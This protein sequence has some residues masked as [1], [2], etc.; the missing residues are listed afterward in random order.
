MQ[1][2]SMTAGQC[3]DVRW[4]PRPRQKRASAFTQCSPFAL[5]S[6]LYD[7][8]TLY[9]FSRRNP[10]FSSRHVPFDSPK[11]P[12]RSK[13]PLDKFRADGNRPRIHGLEK[14]V[15][16]A[17]S[18]QLCFLPWALGTM[19]AWS[20]CV[21][22]AIAVLGFALALIPREYEEVHRDGPPGRYVPWRKLVRFPAFWIGV[23]LLAYILI[24]ALN[25][26]WT[27][28]SNEN[29]W[30]VAR[31]AHVSWLPTSVKSPFLI[32][33]AWRALMVAATVVMTVSTIWIGLSRRRS[34][35]AV[36]VVLVLNG[37]GFALMGIAQKLTQTTDMLWSMSGFPNYFFATIIYKNHAAAYLNLVMAAAIGLALWHRQDAGRRL[38]RSDPSAV[39]LLAALTCFVAD[40]FTGSRLG[41]LFG[42]I[43]LLLG[44]SAYGVLLLSQ[45][46]VIGNPAPLLITFGLLII[47]LGLGLSQVNWTRLSRHFEALFD[48]QQPNIS[49]DY[50]NQARS[51]TW[52]MF[53]ARPVF[54]WGASAFRYRFPLFQQHY[55][56]IY[57]SHSWNGQ[58]MVTQQLYWEYA[59]NDYVQALAEFGLVGGALIFALLAYTIAR[60]VRHRHWAHPIGYA[61]AIAG[62]AM[63]AHC[64]ADFQL[65][66]PAN[67]ITFSILLALASSWVAL[68][69]GRA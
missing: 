38:R 17:L 21:S 30:W 51:A 6:A 54:G 9:Q 5:L 55:P 33:D 11:P 20:Q 42:G 48:E 49:I 31:R 12:I 16:V 10:V 23:A 13:T 39:L 34:L 19:H 50:R 43:T 65:H 57:Q 46:H 58:E 67:L 68:E 8:V 27:Y 35:H 62:G 29:S 2:R 18:L 22:F 59:H 44:L 7:W 40:L 53:E 24:Q 26:A 25:P 1:R 37:V 45:R 32:A 47:F 41:M 15:V 28:F 52:D 63:A 61:A 4:R 60:I 3:R 64:W 69:R 36:L 14:T 66:C 56:T